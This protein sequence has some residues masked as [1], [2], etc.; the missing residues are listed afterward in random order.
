MISRQFAWTSLFTLCPSIINKPNNEIQI[1]SRFHSSYNKTDFLQKNKL[2]TLVPS[3]KNLNSFSH[4][5]NASVTPAI[6]DA[7]TITVYSSN[8][9][10][11]GATG[12]D[13]TCGGV[14]VAAF[15]PELEV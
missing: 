13:D 11:I 15:N 2:L 5:F 3:Q 4:L 7:N 10:V 12:E 14:S 8:G 1:G 9:G 6:T